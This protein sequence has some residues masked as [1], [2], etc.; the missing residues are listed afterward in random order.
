MQSG[1]FPSI[2]ACLIQ[3]LKKEGIRG[4]YSGVSTLLYMAPLR[5]SLVFSTY[6]RAYDL[7][8]FES[9][10]WKGMCGGLAAGSVISMVACP[11]EIIK[12]RMQVRTPEG[13]K[14]YSSIWQCV[15][16]IYSTRGVPGFFVGFYM[17]GLREIPGA[18]L[19][20]AVYE[21]GN[22]KLKE[23]YGQIPWWGFSLSG[24][25]GGLAFWGVFYPIDTVKTLAQITEPPS[26]PKVIWKMIME[27]EGVLGFY[28][29]V[30]STAVR[31]CIS[32][33][34]GY[35]TYEHVRKALMSYD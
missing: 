20:F 9:S 1:N 6:R 13:S 4:M 30:T 8:P 25:A 2:T 33:A 14:H 23:K 34:T 32:C 16:A 5:G 35:F 10:V 27:K 18:G 15:K 12:C 28:K 11:F 24:A 26:S 31:T 3:S 7:A 19:F 21:Y 22:S 17:T 29:G